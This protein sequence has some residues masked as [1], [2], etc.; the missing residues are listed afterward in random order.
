MKD[1]RHLVT[2]EHKMAERS[3]VNGTPADW[4]EY[5]KVY[6]ELETAAASESLESGQQ[7]AQAPLVLKTHWT[8][9][10]G[11]ITS[12]MRGLL[13]DGTKLEIVSAVNTNRENREM[14]LTCRERKS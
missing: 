11:G 12:E 6:C 7:V 10:S 4:E 8:P 9:K 13:A 14:V 2:I 1:R 5:S 3:D